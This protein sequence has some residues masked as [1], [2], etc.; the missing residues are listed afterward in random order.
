MYEVQGTNPNN[1]SNH[2]KVE[3]QLNSQ[4]IGTIGNKEIKVQ[5][6]KLVIEE[7]DNSYDGYMTSSEYKSVTLN[8]SKI[9]G[10]LVVQEWLNGTKQIRPQTLPRLVIKNSSGVEVKEVIM[11]YVEPYVY[12]YSI[13][14][15]DLG[16]GEYLYEVQGTNPNNISNHQNVIVELKD[17]TLGNI[18]NYE[19]KII[20]G[21]L[22]VQNGNTRMLIVQKDVE[23]NETINEE[24]KEQQMNDRIN[25]ENI[26][27]KTNDLKNNIV[28]DLENEE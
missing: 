21:K 7:V 19:V 3:I 24:D 5:S 23:E 27:I 28:T 6:G 2:Q 9:S 20:N 13:D 14:I 25:S 4:E 16:D 22:V 10:Q 1:I 11:T 12:S 17:K 18:G 26:E 15:S 8:G